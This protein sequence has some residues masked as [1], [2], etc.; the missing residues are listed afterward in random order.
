MIPGT[1]CS[2][3][4]T[5]KKTTYLEPVPMP[6]HGGTRQRKP[7]LLPGGCLARDRIARAEVLMP[8]PSQSS[9]E[10]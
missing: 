5:I 4:Y 2:V 1:A 7:I 8:T 10:A 3:L 9:G 6:H